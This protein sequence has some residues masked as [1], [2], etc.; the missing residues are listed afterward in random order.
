MGDEAVI[1]AVVVKPEPPW[2]A[3]VMEAE[4]GWGGRGRWRG[5]VS[6]WGADI[7]EMGEGGMDVRFG[8]KLA[9]ESVVD[10]VGI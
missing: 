1:L 4:G 6:F 8:G 3:A 7:G 10:T 5:R 2:E 9:G